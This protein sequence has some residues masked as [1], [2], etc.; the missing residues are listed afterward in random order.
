MGS[1]TFID[2]ARIWDT[3]ADAGNPDP[4]E[5]RDILDKATAL[6]GLTPREA[7]ILLHVEE[8]DLVEEIFRRAGEVKRSVY[9]DRLV[10]FA[11]LYLSNYCVNDC[12]YCGFHS[13][14]EAPRRKL[15]MDEVREQTERLI[16]MGH[17]RLLLEFGEDPVNNPISYVLDVIG[18]VYSVRRKGGEIRRVNINIAATTV[19]NYRL[20]KEAG[21][22]TYQ[23]FQE[24]YHRPTYERLHRRGPK[25][26][27]ARQLHAMDRAFEAGID[28]LGIGA[29]FGLHDW[30]FE[31]LG[32]IVH[33]A[34][35]KERFGVGPHTISVPRFRPAETVTISPAAPVTDD[36]FLRLI[37]VLR[38]AVPYTGMIITTRE[39]PEIR[40]K[41]FRIGITQASAASTTTPGGFGD[42]REK[43]VRQF[44][45]S[46]RRSLDEI[47][48]SVMKSGY[49]PSF[50]TACYRKSRTG[51]TFMDL[52][53]PGDIHEFCRPNSILTLMEYLEDHAS[54][55]G[56]ALGME[57]IS[58]SLE[59]LGNPALRKQTEARLER[60]RHG[61]R[62]L[63]F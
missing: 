22:G 43:G 40:E 62:D 55:E 30:R 57:V 15:T 4:A 26:D 46:D 42:S 44:E 33:A 8:G 53:A 18:R 59:E 6:D 50:C 58:R 13:R 54:P 60:I 5:V 7:A 51:E 41:A 36:D 63:Y 32:L 3:L 37:A 27:Y 11:P 9:G 10:L 29:L 12:E 35:L 49:T 47:T 19:E 16:D 56:R 1:D 20:L 31:V 38:L 21:I 25:A 17:K 23:L 39:R 48:L 45:L 28:D 14:N 2:E 24:T 61:E 34:H 52:A